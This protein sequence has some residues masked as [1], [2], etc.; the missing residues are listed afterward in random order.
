MVTPLSHSLDYSLN[1]F[2]KVLPSSISA[3]AVASFLGL[4]LLLALGNKMNIHFFG[5]E[6]R[7]KS[8]NFHD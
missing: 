1:K 8:R 5:L 2:W 4:L 7:G 6:L 3:Q